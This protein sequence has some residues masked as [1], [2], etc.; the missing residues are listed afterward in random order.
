MA[1]KKT[2]VKR[3]AG[4]GQSS[5]HRCV[6][7]GDK[8]RAALLDCRRALDDWMQTYA[9]DFCDRHRVYRARKRIERAGGTLAYIADALG[10]IDEL[11]KETR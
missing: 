10:N 5:A 1:W 9:H 6:D 11:L 8:R 7:R 3:N 2:A 4:R